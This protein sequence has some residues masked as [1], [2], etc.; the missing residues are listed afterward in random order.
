MK[1]NALCNQE[2]TTISCIRSQKN[3]KRKK[4]IS[5]ESGQMLRATGLQ[6][7]QLKLSWS[8]VTNIDVPFLDNNHK[9]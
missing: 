6:L 7:N 9:K 2:N 4:V 3:K 5:S 8:K 1:Y